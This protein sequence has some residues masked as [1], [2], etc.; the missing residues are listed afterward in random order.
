VCVCV[1]VREEVNEFR[2]W[3]PDPTSQHDLQRLFSVYGPLSSS[4]SVCLYCG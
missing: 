4:C 3:N 2:K 1:C